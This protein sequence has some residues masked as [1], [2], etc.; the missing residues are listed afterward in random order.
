MV[1][2]KIAMMSELVANFLNGVVEKEVQEATKPV[3]YD[4][5]VEWAR[6]ADESQLEDLID[7]LEHNR[8][9][10]TN[11]Y[12]EDN[13]EEYVSNSSD[14]IRRDEIDVDVVD[15]CDLLQECHERF[16]R[17]VNSYDLKDII[18]DMIDQ[19]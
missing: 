4:S 3:D 7:Y 14:Y 1:N 10:V 5:V 17:D 15:E 12:L 11:K 6:T 16:I 2:E 8:P 19:I 18:K 13:L 9:D